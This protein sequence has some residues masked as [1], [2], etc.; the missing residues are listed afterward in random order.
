MEGHQPDRVPTAIPRQQTR[1]LHPTLGELFARHGTV[2]QH[3]T[4]AYGRSGYRLQEFA[5]YVGVHDAP[6]S[7]RLDMLSR[8]LHHCKTPL[9]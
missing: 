1:A 7:W 6:V 2:D 4:T 8:E 3:I 5:Q 9:V